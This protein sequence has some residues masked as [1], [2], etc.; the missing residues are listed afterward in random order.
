MVV[1][2]RHG[3]KPDGNF[4]ERLVA[5]VISSREDPRFL[6]IVY[7]SSFVYYCVVCQF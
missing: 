6:G 4:T 5:S 1:G 2:E 7:P 3:T